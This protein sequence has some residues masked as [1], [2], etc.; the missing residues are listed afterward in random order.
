MAMRAVSEW[1]MDE[2]V[3]HDACDEREGR[4]SNS[5]GKQQKVVS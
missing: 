2:R 1:S 4:E 3:L 5:K